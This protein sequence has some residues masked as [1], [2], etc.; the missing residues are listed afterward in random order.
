MMPPVLEPVLA[1]SPGNDRL[2]VGKADTVLPHVTAE[3]SQSGASP[4]AWQYFDARG[5]PLAV[6][7]HG[8]GEVLEPADATAAPPARPARQV[9]VSRIDL[10]LAHAQ[11]R[12]DLDIARRVAGGE[13]LT[14]ADRTRMVRVQGELT[15]VLTMLGALDTNL[16]PTPQG[17]DAGSWWHYF[18][19]H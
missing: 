9:L 11:L 13:P 10:V 17:P 18:W 14:D 4:I 8:A 7:I 19:A 2:H 16:D 5:V 1:V 12:L 15:D 3:R 6:A